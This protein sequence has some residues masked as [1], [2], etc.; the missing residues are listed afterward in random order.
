MLVPIPF[1]PHVN[2]IQRSLFGGAKLEHAAHRKDVLCS[3]ETFRARPAIVLP[4]QTDSIVGTADGTTI[5]L[6]LTAA[7]ADILRASPTTAYRISDAII[8]D[9][10]VYHGTFKAFIAARSQFRDREIRRIEQAGLAT[11][12]LAARY[13]GHWLVDD[14]LQYELAQEFGEPLCFP[15][16]IYSDHRAFYEAQLQQTCSFTSRAVV[17]DLAVYQDF[18]WGIHQNSLRRSLTRML[19]E[20]ACKSTPK[21]REHLIYFRRGT[22]GMLRVIQHEDELVRRLEQNGF[23]AIDLETMTLAEIHEALSR[24]K[25]VVSM[26]GSH[27]SHGIFSM[28]EDSGLLLLQPPDRFL[29]FHRG[30]TEAAGIWF[31]FTVGKMVDDGYMFAPSDILRT[32]DLMLNRIETQAG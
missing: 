16:P 12:H 5:A 25:I 10:S 27:V 24:A 17:K 21:K 9:G 28:P 22:T 3:E 15:L 32:L 19:R 8:V 20:R 18:Y 4:G 11:S 29:A 30:W 2:Y 1:V 6:E 13:F 31:G 14:S 26:E 7:A 23:V